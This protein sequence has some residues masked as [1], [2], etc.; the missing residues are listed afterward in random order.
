MSTS[1]A[2]ST[3]ASLNGNVIL[4]AGK[5][6]TQIGSDVIALT[7][8]IGISAERVTIME[9]TETSQMRTES[10]FKQSGLTVA[11][12][13]PVISAVQTADKMIKAAGQTSDKRMQALAAANVGFAGASAHQCVPAPHVD[14][15]VWAVC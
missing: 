12:S 2:G 8:D 4:S 3:V 5:N 9:A 6:Y 15:G 11:L 14:I 1:A 7:G 10:K 13:N